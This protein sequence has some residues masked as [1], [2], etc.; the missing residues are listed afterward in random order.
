MIPRQKKPSVQ[1]KHELKQKV[2]TYGTILWRRDNTM[3]SPRQ[4]YYMGILT[5]IHPLQHIHITLQLREPI[6]GK[7]K[8]WTEYQTNDLFTD[9]SIRD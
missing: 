9:Q 4:T 6:V 3:T 7:Y 2:Y 1:G 8:K 5:K